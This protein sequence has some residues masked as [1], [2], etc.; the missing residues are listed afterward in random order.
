MKIFIHSDL[1]GATSVSTIKQI[2]PRG[3]PD[4]DFARTQLAED[5]SAAARGCFDAGAE[6][7][8]VLD[9]HGGGGNLTPDMLDERIDLDRKENKRWHG[10][11]DESYDATFFIGAHAM[12]GTM[13]AFL[14]HT[15]S[16]LEWHDYMINGKK[17]GELAI[18]ATVAGY[19]DV[20]LVMVSG[21]ESA[22][23]EAHNFFGE[24]ECVAVKRATSRNF[25]K[26]YDADECRKKIYDAA[27]KAVTDLKN[28]KK[29][30]TF[31]PI[32]P[33]EI[34]IEF[35]RA[36]YCEYAVSTHPGCERLDARTIRYIAENGLGW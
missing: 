30:A 19:Y 13:T 17:C 25:A 36:D 35:N 15:M 4:Y 24:I 26:L 2:M 20:P 10:R 11:L 22:V 9:S 6:V 34:K 31:K 32:F 33:A 3:T 29:F 18:W 12:S 1:E 7:V 14:D 8:T 23:V 27:F 28:G 5:V 16:S 21:D